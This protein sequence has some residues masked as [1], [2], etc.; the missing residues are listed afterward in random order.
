MDYR[1]PTLQYFLRA[2]V[3]GHDINSLYNC[4]LTEQ[5]QHVA[6]QILA[7]A[8]NGESNGKSSDNS[9]SRRNLHPEVANRL[10]EVF[11]D[12]GTSV[13]ATNDRVSLDLAQPEG[14]IIVGL[15]GEALLQSLDIIMRRLS[16]RLEL[17]LMLTLAKLYQVP[18]IHYAGTA[19]AAKT[20]DVSFCFISRSGVELRCELK[21]MGKGN[22]ESTESIFSDNSNIVIVDK[23]SETERCELHQFRKHWVELG[24]AEGYKRMFT[25]FTYLDI[26]CSEFDGDLDTA[27]DSIIPA[28]FEEIA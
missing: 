5:L 6:W 20:E 14:Q 4:F 2:L 3:S 9:V 18:A 7:S 10:S 17:P 15:L 26:P 21:L 12:I 27:L 13:K 16:K 28:V 11:N 22:P 19:M 8:R 1:N 24:V 23:A 25:V